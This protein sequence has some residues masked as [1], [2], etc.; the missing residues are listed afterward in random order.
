MDDIQIDLSISGDDIRYLWQLGDF[1]L[2]YS[3]SKNKW[4]KG[5]QSNFLKKL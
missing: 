2:I 5:L 3:R 1:C 4:F